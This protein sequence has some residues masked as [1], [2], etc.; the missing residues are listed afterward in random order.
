MTSAHL[1]IGEVE[2][3]S[4]VPATTLR[5]YDR[6]GLITPAGRVGDKRRFDPAVLRRL[7][8]IS[9]CTEAGFTLDEVRTLLLDDSD[10]R[11]ASRE[12]AERKLVEL[13]DRRRQLDAAVALIERGMRCTCRSI[14]ACDCGA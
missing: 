1:A 8:A 10:G 7:T 5:Y 6:I 12:L 4:G 9:L 14:D 11:V 13:E 2:R 3:L